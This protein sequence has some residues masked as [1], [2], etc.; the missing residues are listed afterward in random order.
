MYAPSARRRSPAPHLRPFWS[1][2][3]R[4]RID[5]ETKTNE[6][7]ALVNSYGRSIPQLVAPVELLL[8]VTN[9]WAKSVLVYSCYL[10]S[11]L[12]GQ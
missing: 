2:H 12:T 1:P 8:Q 6:S 4:Q 10:N 11:M 7:K 3:I 5:S 9:N